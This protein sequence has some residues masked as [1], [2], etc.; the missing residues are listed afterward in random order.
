VM[1]NFCAEHGQFTVLIEAYTLLGLAYRHVDMN[2]LALDFFK[3]AMILSWVI[4]D[5]EGELQAY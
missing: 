1:K 5:R 3:R 2:L 4:L